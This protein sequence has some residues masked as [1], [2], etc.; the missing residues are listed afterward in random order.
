[1]IRI[2][3]IVFFFVSIGVRAQEF[4]IN[5]LDSLLSMLENHDKVMGSI[6]VFQGDKNIYQK[7]TGYA[8]FD[9]KIKAG[10]ATQY[11]IG[12]VTKIY[13]ATLA[14][15]LIEEGKLSLEAVLADYL[16]QLPN[17]SKI[18]I[19]Q[20]LQ[21]ES[22]FF[23]IIKSPDF[24]DWMTQK[25]SRN[26]ILTRILNNGIVFE[27]GQKVEYS[28]TNY[29]LLGFI[30]EDIEHKNYTQVLNER[31]ISPLKLSNTSYGERDDVQNHRAKSYKKSST[32][33][34]IEGIH[35]SIPGGAGAIT[36]NPADMNIFI[37]AL[38]DGKLVNDN[39][40]AIMQKVDKK[41]GI[42]LNPVKLIEGEELIG[43]TGGMDG[44]RSLLVYLPKRNISV[45]LAVNAIDYSLKDLVMG[46]FHILLN[47]DYNIPDLESGNPLKDK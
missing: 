5:K 10:N 37:K 33:E 28:N 44:F 15:L 47:K 29:I 40:L 7:S 24:N 23:D 22:G 36:S 38:F 31:I 11:R 16:P 41:Y 34:E 46:I 4:K 45:S 25:R 20:L 19:K 9:K 6:S 30:I 32:W 43:H 39:S 14:M 12:S 42:G 18:T 27:P 17:A 26:E 13:T 8:D 1:M 35:L 3:L 21:H 2:L